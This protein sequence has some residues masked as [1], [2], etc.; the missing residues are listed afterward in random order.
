MKERFVKYSLKLCWKIEVVPQSILCLIFSCPTQTDW[1]NLVVL[2]N[3][4]GLYHLDPLQ[5]SASFSIQITKVLL[6]GKT[7][8]FLLLM[9][10]SQEEAEEKMWTLQQFFET[11]SF[12]SASHLTLKHLIDALPWFLAFCQDNYEDWCPHPIPIHCKL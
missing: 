9:E 10:V 7:K 5:K 1:K 8:N 2:T 4:L 12:V 3:Y 11:S 6:W